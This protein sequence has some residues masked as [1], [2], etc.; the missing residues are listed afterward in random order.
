MSRS[1]RLFHPSGLPVGITFSRATG[2]KPN[3]IRVTTNGSDTMFTL[4]NADAYGVYQRAVDE[5]LE[6]LGRAADTALRKDMLDA[7]SRFCEH[8]QLTI[9]PRTINVLVAVGGVAT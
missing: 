6:S 1:A 2:A 4:E 3:A 5:R 9:K 7:F 8:Y